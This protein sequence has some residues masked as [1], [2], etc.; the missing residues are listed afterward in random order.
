MICTIPTHANINERNRQGK[1]IQCMTEHLFAIY[2]P[3]KDAHTNSGIALH[4]L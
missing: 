1:S 3:W 4:M 2:H